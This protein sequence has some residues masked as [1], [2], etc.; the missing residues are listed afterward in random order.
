MA[1]FTFQITRFWT[2]PAGNAWIEWR[3]DGF[4]YA[5]SVVYTEI[6]TATKLAQWILNQSTEPRT[7]Q[8]TLDGVYV[9]TYAGSTVSGAVLTQTAPHPV[10]GD[11]A[12][13]NYT[14]YDADGTLVFYGNATVW[15]YIATAISS[16]RVVGAALSAM[17]N[18]FYAYR[19]NTGQSVEF[20]PQEVGHAYSPGTQIEFHVHWV[21]GSVDASIRAVKWQIEYS[22]VT[23]SAISA[24][25]AVYSA[26]TTISAET[27]IPANTPAMSEITT[28]VGTL[29]DAN[30]KMGA[31]IQVR[32]TRIAAAGTAP[33][34]NPYLAQVGIHIEKNTLGS[35][36]TSAK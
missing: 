10:A 14:Y 25:F 15:D 17:G 28:V 12:A 31:R 35:R 34:G 24:P 3:R 20:D 2:D 23:N 18:G 32:V 30:M 5:R 22:Y 4:Y 1:T 21:A 29:L 13:G 33:S 9:A 19:L 26:T 11:L 7:D 16:A 6:N 36:T 27:S 8:P